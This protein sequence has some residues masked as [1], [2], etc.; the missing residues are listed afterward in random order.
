MAEGSPFT[1]AGFSY[2]R[3]YLNDLPDGYFLL[4]L[5]NSLNDK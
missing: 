3:E 5:N 2:I 1:K 4:F